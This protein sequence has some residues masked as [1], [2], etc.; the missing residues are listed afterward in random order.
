[1]PSRKVF[2]RIFR[3][4][5]H[6]LI[7]LWVFCLTYFLRLHTDLIPWMQRRVS[8]IVIQELVL[9]SI[10]SGFVFVALWIFR[11]FYPLKKHPHR[12][13]QIFLKIRIY[14]AIISLGI[15]YLWQWVV[16]IWWISRLIILRTI[17]FSGLLIMLF[18]AFFVSFC[19]RFDE[20]ILFL[21]DK[22]TNLTN[23]LSKSDFKKFDYEKYDFST[24]DISHISK[25]VY[26]QVLLV[27]TLPK[28][29]IEILFDAIR[30]KDIECYHITENFFLEDII[31]QSEV[32]HGVKCL[33]YESTTL[34]E[35]NLVVKRIFDII[36]SSVS[37]FLLSPLFLVLVI[38][39]KI[40]SKWP[41]IY[42]SK[43]VGQWWKLFEFYKFRSMIDNAE[44]H[45]KNLSDQNERKWPLFKIENDPRI[46][47]LWSFLRKSSLD[48][49]AQLFNVFLWNMSLVWP[50]PHLQ[51]EVNNYKLRQK[52]LLSIKPWIT[53]YAQIKGRHSLSF[54][55]EAM[56]DLQYIQ[57]WN[58]FFD[59]YIMI[60]TVKIVFK[61]G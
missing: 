17:L 12:L 47:K 36:V 35:W 46:T 56:Y 44:K 30:G 15:A 37:I 31:Y 11:K 61:W 41:V 4:L 60:M 22:K 6:F 54:D 57:S 23:L 33:K 16:F 25:R 52:R 40:D 8:E 18:D 10:L 28:E 5:V 29:K 7:I 32:L 21:Y 13:Q 2:F 49:L 58:L 26:T 14:W 43:R 42:K 1:M 55:Q 19:Y 34:S 51:S 3:A 48:E 24:F 59:I 9:Y 45:K 27:W 53:G 38:L 39:I 50:R 20:M